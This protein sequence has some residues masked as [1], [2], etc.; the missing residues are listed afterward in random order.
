MKLSF[1]VNNF[2]KRAASDSR[3]LPSHISLFMAIFYYSPDHAVTDSFQICRRNLMKFSRI[4]SIATYHKCMK[5]LVEYGYINY[6]PSYHRFL[7]SE[8]SINHING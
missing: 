7:A 3:L 6:K 4:K 2:L 1:P 5:E 8:V